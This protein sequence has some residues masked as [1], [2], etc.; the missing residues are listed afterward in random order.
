[1]V[2]ASA[3]PIAATRRGLAGA[4]KADAR[5][6]PPAPRPDVR[7]QLLAAVGLCIAKSLFCVGHCETHLAAGSRAARA[8]RPT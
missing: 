7:Q 6:T 3:G 1:M 5:K 2:G 4:P 8:R